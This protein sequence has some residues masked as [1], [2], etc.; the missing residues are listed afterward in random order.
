[1]SKIKEAY[2]KLNPKAAMVGGALVLTTSIG[3][4]Q[5]TKTAMEEPTVEETPLVVP[6]EEPE[7]EA[8][9]VAA[10]EPEAPESE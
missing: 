6:V 7:V 9:E 2:R 5:L 3:T 10:E 1:M 4:C 8:E